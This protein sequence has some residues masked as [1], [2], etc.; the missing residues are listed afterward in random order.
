MI[1]TVW[2]LHVTR[3][4]NESELVGKEP[5]ISPALIIGGGGDHRAANVGGEQGK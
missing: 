1:R 4:L 5:H 3:A 2:A